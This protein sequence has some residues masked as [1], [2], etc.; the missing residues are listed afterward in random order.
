M[1]SLFSSPSPPK[2]IYPATP[3]PTQD[4]PTTKAKAEGAAASARALAQRRMGSAA[5]ILTPPKVG[6]RSISLLGGG[7]RTA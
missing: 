3:P 4:D 7:E 5:N 2:I 1:G 6:P